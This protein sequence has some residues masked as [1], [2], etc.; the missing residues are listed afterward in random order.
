LAS[1]L[2]F[3]VCFAGG[4]LGGGVTAAME[5]SIVIAMSGS[6]PAVMV[7]EGHCYRLRWRF[8]EFVAVVSIRNQQKII[9]SW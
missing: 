3:L 7:L 4:E 2:C 9:T 6:A 8:W 5:V 1:H